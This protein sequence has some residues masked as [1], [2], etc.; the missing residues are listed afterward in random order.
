MVLDTALLNT[1]H[2][3]VRIKGKEKQSREWI[4]PLAYT[5]V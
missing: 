5:L 1:E 3:K 2:Y 4:S